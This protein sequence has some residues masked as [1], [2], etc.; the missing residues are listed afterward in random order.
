MFT[1]KYLN[2]S[3]YGVGSG[4]AE[5]IRDFLK[6]YPNVKHVIVDEHLASKQLFNLE[7]C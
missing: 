1:Q 4:K 2:Y 3:E 7:N 5:E 6:D